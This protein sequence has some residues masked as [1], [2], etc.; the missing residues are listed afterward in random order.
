MDLRN[1]L[2]MNKDF[3]VLL[4]RQEPCETSKN[5]LL[6][7]MVIKLTEQSNQVMVS[8]LEL[9]QEKQVLKEYI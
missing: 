1:A 4:S 2:I 6:Y 8:N 7:K 5:K 9:I 3:L